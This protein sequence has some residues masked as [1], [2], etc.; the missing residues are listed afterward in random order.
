MLKNH[1]LA[2][3]LAVVIILVAGYLADN[4]MI[5]L[6]GLTTAIPISLV[7]LFFAEDRNKP[8]IIDSFMKGMVIYFLCTVFLYLLSIL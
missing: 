1:I 6:A 2:A 4:D 7:S 3:F 8:E 5:K